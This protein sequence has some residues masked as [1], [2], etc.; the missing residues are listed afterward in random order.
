MIMVKNAKLVLI[1]MLE[2]L[3]LRVVGQSPE[4]YAQAV[5]EEF[6]SCV[7]TTY[8]NIDADVKTAMGQIIHYQKGHQRKE[9][10]R[11]MKRLSADLVIRIQEQSEQFKQ[12]GALAQHCIHAMEAKMNAVDL[13]DPIYKNLTERKFAELIQQ[14]LKKNTTCEFAAILLELGLSNL[15]EDRQIQISEVRSKKAATGF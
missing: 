14:A 10:E 7:N 5:A 6:C 2:I 1:V 4:T 3:A 11:Y 13:S 12:N 8:S 15:P 9:L